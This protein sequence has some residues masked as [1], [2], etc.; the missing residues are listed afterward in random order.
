MRGWLK[1][2]L[3][4]LGFLLVYI[5]GT[6]IIQSRIPDF[7]DMISLIISI[8]FIIPLV[9]GIAVGIL[10]DKLYNDKRKAWL[11]GSIMGMIIGVILDLIVYFVW[12]FIDLKN[13][14]DDVTC[15]LGPGIT[16]IFSILPVIILF[17][18]I[19]AIIGLVIGKIKSKKQVEVVR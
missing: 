16:F 9:F 2:G 15:G 19:G 12:L 4:S 14:G 3:I 6:A 8:F 13:C 10:Y 7:G 1:G 11:K 5:I 17:G 18:I